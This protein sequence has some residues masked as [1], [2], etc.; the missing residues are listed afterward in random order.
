M[1]EILLATIN[2]RY[3][4]ASFGLRCLLANLGDL[5]PRAAMIE[6]EAKQNPGDI[7]ERILAENP[8]VVGLGIYVWNAT[9]SAELASI[10]KRAR[11]DLTLVVGGPEVSH[12]IDGQPVC[13]T[14]DYVVA[15]EGDLAFA[16]LCRAILSGDPPPG[17]ILRPPPPD[18]AALAS[19]YGEYTDEDLARRTLYV[20]ASRGCPFS[21]EFCLSSLDD[22]VRAFPPG[23]FLASMERLLDRGARSFKFVDRT[24]N[25]HPGAAS[26]ILSFFHARFRPGMFLHFEM[27]PDRLPP[28]IREWIAR[29]P[30]GTLQ[31]EVGV[32]TFDPA[33]AANISRRQDYAKL[34]EN[35]RF[36][37]ERTGAHLHA[38]L[39]VGLPGESA[40]SFGRGFDRLVA[41]GPQ[42]IQVGLLKRLRGAPVARHD[43]AVV[44]SEF[45]PYEVLR[46]DAIGFPEMRRLRRFA[47][48]WDLFANSGNFPR[49]LPLLW[50]GGASPF[51][52]FSDL[53]ERAYREFGRTDSIS[54]GALAETLFAHLVETLGLPAESAGSAVAEDYLSGGRNDLPKPLRPFAARPGRR[55]RPEGEAA[56]PPKRQKRHLAGRG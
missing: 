10:L 34:E 54:L 52:R 19:P 18:L 1:P 20:E 49:S 21:C 14:A 12:E 4:H 44:C 24:F 31:I 29:F 17:R 28:A 22:G 27:V 50:A 33:A 55:T 7:A 5:R 40:E 43:G 51:A 39:I 45:P 3:H 26:A 37:R 6:F 53:A 46:T 47:R 41:L 48:F 30:P 16:A 23:P 9:P 2:A 42:E 36:L 25:L 13:R 38:D 56:A 8:R 35:I 32:Q 15:G 11:P